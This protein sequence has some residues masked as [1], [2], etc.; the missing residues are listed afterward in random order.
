MKQKYLSPLQTVFWRAAV[1]S[2]AAGIMILIG[3]KFSL[4]EPFTAGVTIVFVVLVAWLTRKWVKSEWPD[5]RIRRGKL[6]KKD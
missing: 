6:F 2:E 1:L 5:E 3:S 4:R